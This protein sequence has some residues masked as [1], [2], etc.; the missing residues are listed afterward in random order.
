VRDGICREHRAADA[1]NTRD[2]DERVGRATVLISRPT[3]APRDPMVERRGRT[4]DRF[5]KILLLGTSLN[6][7]DDER[8][9]IAN[10]S[11]TDPKHLQ[12][13]GRSF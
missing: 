6:I 3:R 1:R 10:K 7:S 11:N 4:T 2:D 13:A 12:L 9:K 8:G 5:G